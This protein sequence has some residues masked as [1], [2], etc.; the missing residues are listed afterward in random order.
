MG[1]TVIR[2]CVGIIAITAWTLV[3]FSLHGGLNPRLD[4]SAHEESGK[5]MAQAALALL[6]PGGQ[7][8][9][10]A[11]D[12]GA[13][14]NPA[15][16]IQLASFCKVLGQAHATIRS[17]R[18]LQVDPLRS[19]V[20][21]SSDFCELIRS[22]PEGSVIASFMGPPVLTAAERSGL[23][24]VKPAIVAFCSGNLPASADLRTLF[25]QGL[26]QA[27]VVDRRGA[28][29]TNP[30]HADQPS[31]LTVTATNLAALS[32]FRGTGS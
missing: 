1:R 26:L 27:A 7:V 4:V 12:T 30:R 25:D 15:S 16:D 21:P 22:T 9:I 32:A 23:G 14:G 17:V 6:E 3:G 20:V 2:I 10:I 28:E 5:L 24:D 29:E 18:S 19:I 13:F 11:R 8:T 31:F